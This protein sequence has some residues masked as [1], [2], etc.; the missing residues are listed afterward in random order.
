MITAIYSGD[1]NDITSTS[2]A[3][4][5]DVT[6]DTTT[7]AVSA[8][9]TA[10]VY[11][12]SVKFKATVAVAGPGAGQP[13]GTVTSWT[14]RRRSA[15]ARSALPGRHDGDFYDRRPG[16]RMYS[17]TAVY[18]GDTDDIISTSAL[19]TFNVAQNVTTAVVTASPACH[20]STGRR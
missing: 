3:L 1:T 15:P 11:G 12:Q 10:T 4:A 18:S 9:P 19:L 13:T 14:A 5:F 16:R 2:P 6:Q 20:A 17:I 7:A 8:S